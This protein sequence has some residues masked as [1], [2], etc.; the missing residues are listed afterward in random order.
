[1]NPR[2]AY[3]TIVREVAKASVAPPAKRNKAIASSFR[4]IFTEKR[5]DTDPERFNAD[6]QNAITFIRSQRV[7]KELLD[8]YNPLFDLTAEERIEATAHRVG[9]NMPL[10]RKMDEEA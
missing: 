7:Y 9:L 5:P 3:R 10:M 8:R 6:I 4:T 1:M 2:H